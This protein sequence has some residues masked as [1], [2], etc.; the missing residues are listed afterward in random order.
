MKAKALI[1]HQATTWL[2]E[3]A[4]IVNYDWQEILSGHILRL[5]IGK[6]Q[7]IVSFNQRVFGF[8]K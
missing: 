8:C 5:I 3:I 2:H 6:P 7:I 4:C 1:C